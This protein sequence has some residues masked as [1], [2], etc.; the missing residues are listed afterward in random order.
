MSDEAKAA[1]AAANEAIQAVHEGKTREMWADEKIGRVEAVAAAYDKGFRRGYAE[2]ASSTAAGRWI[3][4]TDELPDQDEWVL[5][6]INK[7]AQDAVYRTRVE[8]LVA[9]RTEIVDGRLEWLTD[10]SLWLETVTH[11]ARVLMP[12]EKT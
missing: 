2:G 1:I 6:R 7:Q 8:F 10:T 9:R 12:G 3:A 4:V 5:V 11:W